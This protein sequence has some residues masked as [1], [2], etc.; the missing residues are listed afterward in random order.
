MKTTLPR[1]YFV[2]MLLS[3]GLFSYENKSINHEEIKTKAKEVSKEEKPSGKKTFKHY[4][5]Y[6]NLC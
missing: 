5:R 3:V 4:Y 2:F 1:F 6:S